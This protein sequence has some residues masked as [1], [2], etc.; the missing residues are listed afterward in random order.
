MWSVI[1]IVLCDL[2]VMAVVV[3]LLVVLVMFP[4]VC[5]AT[6]TKFDKMVKRKP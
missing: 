1:D 5:V 2:V 6:P 4:D 3:I